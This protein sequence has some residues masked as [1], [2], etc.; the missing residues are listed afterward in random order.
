MRQKLETQLRL[1]NAKIDT[2]L[3]APYR[4]QMFWL[5][6]HINDFYSAPI[7]ERGIAISLS[8]CVCLSAS[9]PLEPL[10]RSSRNFCG[11][12]LWPWLGHPRAALR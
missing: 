11:D 10:D 3:C 1:L 12:P 6:P 5:T 7:G 9:I 4:F 2:N 8:A